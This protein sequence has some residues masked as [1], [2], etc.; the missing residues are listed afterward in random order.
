[1]L[2]S[3]VSQGRLKFLFSDNSLQH[4]VVRKIFPCYEISFSMNQFREL[5]PNFFAKIYN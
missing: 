2:T 1:M 5:H 4:Y 3:E